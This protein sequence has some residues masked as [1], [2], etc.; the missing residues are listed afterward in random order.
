MSTPLLDQIAGRTESTGVVRYRDGRVVGGVARG[1]AARFDVDPVVVRVGFVIAAF[2]GGLG[3]AL[4]LIGWLVLPDDRGQL[5]LRRALHDHDGAAWVLLVGAAVASLGAVVSL[6]TGRDSGRLLSVLAIGAIV[7]YVVRRNR[8]DQAA[9]GTGTPS[10]DA[11]EAGGHERG[12]PEAGAG[13]A[14][15]LPIT[16]APTAQAGH[17]I[18][19]GQPGSMPVITPWGG[20][21]GERA[22]AYGRGTH[23]SAYAAAPQPA[24]VVAAP[25]STRPRPRR[26]SL[27][28]R[29]WLVAAGLALLTWPAARAIT[30]ATGYDEPTAQLVA[31]GAT[32]VV[33]GLLVL[34]L[35]LRGYRTS[36]LAIPTLVLALI[37]ASGQTAATMTG[38]DAVMG[39][40]DWQPQ[41]AAELRT[42][43][44]VSMGEGRL[45]LTKVSAADLA[46]RTITVTAGMGELRIRVP[47][48][49]RVEVVPKVGLGEVRIDDGQTVRTFEGFNA[50]EATPVAIGSGDKTLRLQASSGMGEIRVERVTR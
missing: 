30:L 39:E 47:S 15:S 34:V 20:R 21:D 18:V 6:V 7:W 9:A 49:V 50:G 3:V 13:A 38:P 2:A 11:P 33:L 27:G 4:Y 35:G 46:G 45:D 40:V 8:S 16:A 36:G 41:S 44:A 1:L 24:R 17:P 37:A 10:I 29:I 25:V 19:T 26:R 23:P 5:A 31:A 32:A 48:D 42:D 14:A 12:T 28:F 22:V 43:Y